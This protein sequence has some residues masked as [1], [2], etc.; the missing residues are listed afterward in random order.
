M[1]RKIL[2]EMCRETTWE[3]LNFMG[4]SEMNVRVNYETSCELAKELVT[5]FPK[6]KLSIRETLGK[7]FLRG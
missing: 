3:V 5:N 7:K 4:D 6:Q 1:A 2:I